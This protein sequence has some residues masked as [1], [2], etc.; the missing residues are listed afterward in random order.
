VLAVSF[1][2]IFHERKQEFG[3]LRVIGG[4]KKKLAQLASSEALLISSAG[5]GIGTIM[6]CV[7]VLLFNQAIIAGLQMPFLNPSVLW[8]LMCGVITF[9]AIAV[10]G[11]LSAF[12]TIRS[13]TKQEPA[14]QI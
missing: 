5:A 11:P 6:G 1:S 13:I 3:M 14:L 7:V 12:N 4:T 8:T 10:I 2:S 9:S